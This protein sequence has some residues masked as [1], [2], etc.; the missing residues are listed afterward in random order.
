VTVEDAEPPAGLRG[1]AARDVGVQV[2]GRVMNLG[3]GLVVTVVIVRTLGV[4]GNGYW[5][6]LIAVQAIV[7]TL[8]ELGLEA[9]AVRRAAAAPGETRSWLGTLLVLRIALAVPAAV[10]ALGLGLALADTAAMR[11]AAVL[12]AA[13][14]VANAPMSLR[15]AFQLA[16]R[17]DR[18]IAVITF[19]SLIWTLAVIGVAV[20]DAGLVAFAAAMLVTTV[21][22]T[23][24]QTV[25]VVR[26]V[27][28]AFDGLR[29]HGPDL[30][31]VGVVVGVGA[32][33]TFA[34]ARIDQLLVLHYNGERAAGLYGTAYL[35]L[36]RIQVIPGAVMATAFPVLSAAWPDRP[37]RT[38]DL[39][40][41]VFEVMALIG[42]PALAFTI[43]ASRPA[44]V[45][46]FGDDFGPAAAVLPILMLAFVST[47]FGYLL[48]FLSL[49]VDRQRTFLW[50]SL[51]ALAL[52]LI[53]NAILLPRYGYVA[54]AWVTVATEAVVIVSAARVVL[55][56]LEMRLRLGRLP[57]AVAAAAVMG[58]A[59]AGC[60]QL[61][62]GAAGLMLIAAAVYPV[63]VL[64]CGA[65]SREDRARVLDRLR[66]SG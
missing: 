18:T 10:I 21:I 9:T 58:L 35:L 31:R 3:L 45:L 60:R 14:L 23:L 24:V 44:L 53:A 15:A 27:G 19:N 39:T 64:A 38:R 57:N 63:A 52:N 30:L 28:V 2:V 41:Q 4:A 50:I 7:G 34:Y 22:T 13:V 8:G 1:R 49:V 26:S 11:V 20:L 55:T 33:L 42:V 43:V 25:W 61:G 37:Q 62:V 16:M 29:R 66:R 36:D 6:T 51:A 65:V 5:A 48:G 56:E 17:N 59:V 54:A 46:V 40:Q 47:C 12:L 32:A